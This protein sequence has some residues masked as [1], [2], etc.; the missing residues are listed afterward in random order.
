[1]SRR[2][3]RLFGGVIAIGAS[4]LV[5]VIACG[6]GDLSRLTKGDGTPTEP[7]PTV[8][9]TDP[10]KHALPPARP[11]R[12]EDPKSLVLFWAT[13]NMRLDTGPPPDSGLS[14]SVGYDIDNTCTCGPA[15]AAPSC[16]EPAEALK[17]CDLDQKGRDNVTGDLLAIALTA[18]PKVLSGDAIYTRIHAG[19]YSVLVGINAWNGTPND[20]NVGVSV[21]ISG[22]ADMGKDENANL[23]RPNF[24]GNDIWS[25]APTS[26]HEGDSKIGKDCNETIPVCDAIA[27]DAAAYVADGTL[28]AN[29]GQVPFA[30]GDKSAFISIPFT[31]AMLIAKIGGEEPLFT[32][33]GELIGRW[34]AE[35]ILNAVGHLSFDAPGGPQAICTS[36][37]LYEQFKKQVC[38]S[39]DLA[40]Q[41]VRDNK[42][43]DCTMLSQ[44]VRFTA[45]QAKI[46]HVI[47]PETETGADACPPELDT[48]CTQYWKK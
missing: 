40:T 25:V 9:P 16:K 37:G 10:C 45:T 26:I 44:S 1:M 33:D 42:G 18:V 38:L 5:A 6:P 8:D 24:D 30:F 35:A 32:L 34:P 14:R 11:T 31:D 23:I 15:D 7:T 36:A 21:L 43:D 3:L 29:F 2:S 19:F 41:R 48:T 22:G 12:Q 4:T 47:A 46:G 28:V 39:V 20:D 27:V 13:N 17:V